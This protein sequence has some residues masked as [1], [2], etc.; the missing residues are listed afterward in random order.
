MPLQNRVIPAGEILAIPQRGTMM[1][2][3]GGRLHDVN[4]KRLH[5]SRRW[6]SKQ[7]ICCEVEF[8]DRQREVMGYSYTELF[9]LDE[10]T[11]MAAGHRP[12]FECRRADFLTYAEALRKSKRAKKRMT[13]KQMDDALHEQRLIG[14]EKKVERLFWNDL[15]DG[16]AIA[17]QGGAVMKYQC[18]A[19]RWNADGYVKSDEEFADKL[20]PCL[21]PDLNLAALKAG[22]K[23][24]WHESIKSL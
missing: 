20:V 17:D 19:I 23:P 5:P 15:P 3:R 9:F 4:S 18:R 8:N 16:A 7:W 6:A 10:V 21:T 11:A 2:N 13:A 12:C 22:Y 24:R 14:R 1:G